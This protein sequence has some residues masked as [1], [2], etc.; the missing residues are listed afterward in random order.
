[1]ALHASTS[2]DGHTVKQ[3][4]DVM[5]TRLINGYTQK[6]PVRWQDV[7]ALVRYTQEREPPI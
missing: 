4:P 3:I 2:L 7:Q 1:M 6:G 5:L